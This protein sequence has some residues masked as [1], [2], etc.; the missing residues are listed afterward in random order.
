MNICTVVQSGRLMYEAALLLITYNATNTDSNNQFY[1]CIPKNGINWSSDP[2]KI[3]TELIDF[4]ISQG[5]K[6]S[7]FENS[8]WGSVYPHSNKIY[9]L[10][11]L[12]SGEPFMFLDS[13][14]IILGSISDS[15]M[16]FDYPSAHDEG[17]TFPTKKDGMYSE[18]KIWESL[19]SRFKLDSRLSKI[20]N[21][22]NYFNAGAFYYK[23]P[24]LFLDKFY[25]FAKEIWFNPH[26]ELKEQALNP[27]LDQVCLPLV[28]NSLGGGRGKLDRRI[29]YRIYEK[30]QDI[31]SLDIEEA[32]AFHYHSLY[33][34]Y[35]P[36]MEEVLRKV[37]HMVKPYSKIF[38]E[39]EYF[40]RYLITS[41]IEL[42][43]SESQSIYRI[44]RKSG[45]TEKVDKVL[46]K[47]EIIDSLRDLAI[48]MEEFDVE[49]SLAVMN[50]AK[51]HRP[52]GGVINQKIVE[53]EKLI[54]N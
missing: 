35:L 23:C 8:D 18:E 45:K 2:S 34:L 52:N 50:I 39:N 5:A 9:A 53:Y 1:I 48:L 47:K 4:Y 15:M 26:K 43:M 38:I 36:G 11:C 31:K 14:M 41:K 29:N 10:K 40:Y 33:K 21:K 46:A 17:N 27:W 28:I 22:Y 13:D 25:Y 37:K 51:F 12:P 42:D 20:K 7:Y 44:S 19:Y 24:R 6:I 3:P 49:S 54:S 16:N 30:H 32:I